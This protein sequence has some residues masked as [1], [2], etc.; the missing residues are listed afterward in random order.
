MKGNVYGENYNLHENPCKPRQ[1]SRLNLPKHTHVD[2][3]M[4]HNLIK[5]LV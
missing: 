5:Y 3:M 2:D 1:K 4:I